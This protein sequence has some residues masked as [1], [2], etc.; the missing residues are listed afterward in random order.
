MSVSSF[1]VFFSEPPASPGGLALIVI[2]VS[3]IIKE[4][5][6][7]YKYYLG[8]KYKSS[9]LITEAWHHRSDSL[10]S[11]AALIGIGV[12]MLGQYLGIEYLLYGDAVAGIIVSIIV[13]KVGYDLAKDSS[14]I[15]MEKVLSNDEVK[16]FKKTVFSVQGG[17]NIDQMPARTHGSY[18]IIDIKISVDP[19][20]TVKE[21]HDIATNVK[22]HLMKKH[23][24]IEDVLVHVNPHG[25]I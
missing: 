20:I 12:A 11:F 3:I 4:R 13:I 7:Y 5:L 8:K 21:G 18:V 9:A 1:K 23:N 17:L 14:L 19:H 2:I 25:M 24:N 22:Q 6:F 10:S 16:D 15:M